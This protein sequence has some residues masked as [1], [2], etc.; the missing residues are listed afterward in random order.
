MTISFRSM[1]ERRCY[2]AIIFFLWL[3]AASGTPRRLDLG[4]GIAEGTK[5]PIVDPGPAGLVEEVRADVFPDHLAGARDLE[6]AA[7]DALADQRVAVGESLRP[8]DV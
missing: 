2:A 1:T 8:G 7:V 4:L 5:H 6:D 3:Y